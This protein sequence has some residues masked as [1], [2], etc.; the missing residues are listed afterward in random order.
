MDAE[1][2]ESRPYAVRFTRLTLYIYIIIWLQDYRGDAA[3]ISWG[4]RKVIN[5]APTAPPM[6]REI[7]LRLPSFRRLYTRLRATGY[8]RCRQGYLPCGDPAGRTPRHA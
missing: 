1:R 3:T 5:H 6:K 7:I 8:V 2:D 4:M